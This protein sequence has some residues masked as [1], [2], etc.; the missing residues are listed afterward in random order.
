LAERQH[1]TDRKDKIKSEQ[2]PEGDSNGKARKVYESDTNLYTET[3]EGKPLRAETETSWN[4]VDINQ[5]SLSKMKV[6]SY[7][8]VSTIAFNVLISLIV[9]SLSLECEYNPDR[10]HECS[11]DQHKF[12][13]KTYGQLFFSFTLLL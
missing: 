1:I 10:D 8:M 9:C 11:S 5:D 13:F 2:A 4:T 3:D 12:G 6:S 7:G